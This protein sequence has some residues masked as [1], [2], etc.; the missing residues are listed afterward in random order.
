MADTDYIYAGTASTLATHN[1]LSKNQREVIF[2][3][4]NTTELIDALR[5]TCFAP[6]LQKKV[7]LPDALDTALQDAKQYMLRIAPGGNAVRLFFL[8]YDYANTA[9]L[10]VAQKNALSDETALK[11]CSPL[12]MYTPARLLD[13][14]HRKQIS[15]I[16]Q[17]IGDIVRSAETCCG[18]IAKKHGLHV[19]LERGYILRAQMLAEELN[20]PT[21]R[22]YAT[23]QTDL[24]NI[25]ATLLT[26]DASLCVPN[27]S[28]ARRHLTPEHIASALSLQDNTIPWE[29]ILTASIDTKDRSAFDKALDE[30]YTKQLKRASIDQ[31]SLAPLLL[32]LHTFIENV[33]FLRSVHTAHIVGLN[34]DTLRSLIR[35]PSTDYAY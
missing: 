22:Q 7:S 8:R 33:Q 32:Y 20:T 34:T 18:H 26:K 28:I 16:D 2:S 17:H 1:L 6:Y 13:Y 4:Q 19:V 31:H 23:L 10:L 25:R 11:P 30:F 12:G 14:I 3:T 5:D 27:G 21:L 24:F 9:H 35:T 15:S 29:N